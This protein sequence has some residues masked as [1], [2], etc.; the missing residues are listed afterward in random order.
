MS[1]VKG[2]GAGIYTCQ[3][4]TENGKLEVC[5]E[6]A[7]QNPSYLALHPN[8]KSMY[9]VNELSEG[10]QPT[11]DTVSAYA[12][13]EKTGVPKFLNKQLAYGASPCHVSVEPSGR[14]AYIATYAGGNVSAYP[15]GPDGSLSQSSDHIQHGQS[16][17]VPHAHSINPAPTGEFALVCDLGL[18]RVF[19][20][21]LD[22]QEGKLRPHDEIEMAAGSG[23]R[24]LAY[25]PNGRLVYVINELNGTANTYAWDAHVGKLE[26]MQTISTLPESFSGPG[27]C[28][29]IHVHPNGK[30]V[31]GSNRG[32]HS[33]VIYWVDEAEGK[34]SRLGFEPTRGMTPR[35]FVIDPEGKWLL[36][37]NQD[38]D[39]LVVFGIN[40]EG[41]RLDYLASLEIPTPVCVKF[42]S[43]IF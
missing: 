8:G 25:H 6:T 37:A 14:W 28:A 26:F 40:A 10:D 24:H 4:N 32:D 30:F 7:A 27:W 41:G 5:A 9:A 17:K 2:R 42:A 15:I 35:S 39:A 12:L 23:P 34:L 1:F 31:Y 3:F 33:I 36:A 43:L 11:N 19:I 20:Y 38:S 29:D 13:D 18:D 21:R 22:V 16:G